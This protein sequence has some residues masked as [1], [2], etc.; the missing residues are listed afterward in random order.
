MPVAV[1]PPGQKG[2]RREPREGSGGYGGGV[3]PVPIPNTAVPPSSAYGTERAT[4]R[5]S[6]SPP[7]HS[8]L[9]RP[10]HAGVASFPSARHAV[11]RGECC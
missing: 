5:E 11:S 2:S 8:F 3:P 1:Q 10:P 9:K 4:A 6:R 7:E